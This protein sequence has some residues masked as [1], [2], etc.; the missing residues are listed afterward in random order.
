MPLGKRTKLAG[1]VARKRFRTGPYVASTSM[2][3]RSLRPRRMNLLKARLG[4]NRNCHSFRRMCTTTTVDVAGTE[5]D[6]ASEFKFSDITGA[7]EYAALYDRYMLT[8]V[9]MKIRI[10]NNPNSTAILNTSN[11]PSPWGNTSNWFPR[12]F[13]CPD[14]DN[15]TVETLTQLKERARTKMRVLKPNSYLKYVVKPAVAVQ[16]YRT[17]IAAG[18]SPKWKQWLDMDQTDVPHFGMKF[19]MDMSGL[20][21]QDTQPFKL[22]IEKIYYFKCKDVR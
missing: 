1:N 13:N 18:Y 16:T 2:V 3:P 17:A 22:E 6:F 9:V 10:I 8:T 19:A 11:G 15:S 12:L 7:A 5:Y 4:T 21:P 20:D 14:Y